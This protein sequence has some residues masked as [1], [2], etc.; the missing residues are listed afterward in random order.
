[1][2]TRVRCWKTFD[3]CIIKFDNSYPNVCWKSKNNIVGFE[4]GN[5]DECTYRRLYNRI[6]NRYKVNYLCTDGLELYKHFK[7]ESFNKDNNKKYIPKNIYKKDKDK[8]KD[9][10]KFKYIKDKYS[11]KQ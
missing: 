2:K 1:M 9:K 4:V 7:F 8:D 10:T 11:N 5:R 3:T 6:D